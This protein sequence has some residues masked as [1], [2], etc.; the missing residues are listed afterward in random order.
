MHIGGFVPGALPK[1]LTASR[2][3]LGPL[4][5]HVLAPVGAK[6]ASWSKVRHSPPACTQTQSLKPTPGMLD[7]PIRLFYNLQSSC[8]SENAV[9]LQ[10]RALISGDLVCKH[11]L[12]GQDMQ[13]HLKI[14]LA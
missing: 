8:V 1:C 6:R 11:L 9:D 5:K 4:S 3:F 10:C 12:F 13:H 2:A 14:A 7:K